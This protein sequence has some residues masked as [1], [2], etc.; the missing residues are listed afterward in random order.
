MQDLLNM[1]V[2]HHRIKCPECSPTRRNRH[3]R[4]LSVER[5]LTGVR[6]YCHHC[7][8]K[9]S[10][11][12]MRNAPIIN[13]ARPI[14]Q[15]RPIK[16]SMN[17]PIDYKGEGW[18][19]GR[20]LSRSVAEKFGVY[21]TRKYFNKL[22]REDDAIAFPYKDEKGSVVAVKYRAISDKAFAADGKMD[23]FFGA[24][25]IKGTPEEL[26]IVE[27]EADA[28][29]L[30]EVDDNLAV[31]SVPAGAGAV[32]NG[33]SLPYLWN[34]KELLDKAK[35]IYIGVDTDAP[36]TAFGDELAR[37]LGKH[38]C[39][40]INWSAK[41]ANETLIEFGEQT[42]NTDI[43]NASPYPVSGLYD[44]TYFFDRLDEFYEQGMG[45]GA[46]TGFSNLD[47]LYSV[48]PGQ[49]TVVSGVPNAGKSQFIDQIMVNL[50]KSEGWTFAIASFEN[51]PALHIARLGSM[52]MRKDFFLTAYGENNRM[53]QNELKESKKF[54]KDHFYFLHSNDG[55]L[56]KLDDLL[57]RI[58]VAVLRYGVK[59]V[60]IDPYNYIQKSSTSSE[61][62]WISD[63]LTAVRSMASSYE[64][65][66]WFVA[67]PT[68]LPRRED[69][70]YP[71]PGG[72]EIS[73]SAA[74]YAKADNGLSLGRE[75]EGNISYVKV[76][77]IRFEW[78]GKLG[79]CALLYDP[80]AHEYLEAEKFQGEDDF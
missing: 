23:F 58:K 13:A 12:D 68:K 80:Q 46:S 4:T 72:Y 2:G 76:W 59:G 73:G 8:A 53:T 49:L 39:W 36:G 67:H 29:A 77:K 60:V 79:Q 34:A 47:P 38:R 54:V 78:V 30:K 6:F 56:T 26:I 15:H 62:D 16:V 57:E 21:Q 32:T 69:G 55:G 31:L 20:G 28:L 63:M 37:R 41:D 52:Y 7:G 51:D 44:A 43:E 17:N 19:N 5:D 22:G 71:I 75:S 9:G 61:T 14:S 70:T 65:H 35:K 27:G 40:R 64:V 11:M 45:G 3:D 33:A 48:V 18:L 50:A 24:E 66:V 42:V 25:L 10:Q 1:P 74:W